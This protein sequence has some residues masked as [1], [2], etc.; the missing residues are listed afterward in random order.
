ME[1][2]PLYKIT[3]ARQR[4]EA[5]LHSYIRSK[6]PNHIKETQ[7]ECVHKKSRLKSVNT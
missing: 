2:S 5:N 3:K 6:C 1:N 4:T 7:Y